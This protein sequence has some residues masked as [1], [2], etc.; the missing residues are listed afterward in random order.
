MMLCVQTAP[1]LDTFGID[2]GFRM[3]AEAGF[4]GVDFNIDHAWPGGK[5]RAN[6][7]SGFF[8]L[9]DDEMKEA[10]RPYKEAAEKYGVKFW[11]AHAPFPTFVPENSTNEYILHTLK[12]TIMLMGYLECPNLV[13]HPGFLGDM[14]KLPADAE[15]N[16]NVNMYSALIP[17][18]KKYGVVCCLE[19]MFSGYRGKVVEAICSDFDEAN[20]YIDHLNAV[21]G[22]KLF[23]FCLDVGHA[24]LLGKDI[25]KVIRTLGDRITVLH[26]HDNDGMRDEHLFPY[27]GVTN[28]DR[29]CAGMKEIGFD[30]PLSFETFNALATFDK[31]LWPQMLKLLFATG[32]LFAG[33][34]AN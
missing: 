4:G 11:Q 23:G 8:D 7:C 27:M 17:D 30:K 19:N 22:E 32:E 25:A 12:K 10:M 3:I 33:R 13:V 16:Y 5:I 34:I 29:F 1:I 14:D 6:D 26:V 15:W 28:W 24:T 20:A 9:S 2:E 21:A 18:L 31:A